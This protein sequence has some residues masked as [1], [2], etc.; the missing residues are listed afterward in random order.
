MWQSTFKDFI[1]SLKSLSRVVIGEFH[2]LGFED[3]SAKGL[4]LLRNI[5]NGQQQHLCLG[6]QPLQHGIKLYHWKTMLK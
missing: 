3:C 6:K 1:A 4:N 5:P 2:G